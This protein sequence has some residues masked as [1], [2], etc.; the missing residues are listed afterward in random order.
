MRRRSDLP[1]KEELDRQT[2][3]LTFLP[4]MGDGFHTGYHNVP[5][6]VTDR[7]KRPGEWLESMARH[8]QT[9]GQDVGYSIPDVLACEQQL[10]R[11]SRLDGDRLSHNRQLTDYR[12]VLA[13]LLL[14]DS[15]PRDESWPVLDTVCLSG[16]QGPFG[17]AVEAALAPGR[18]PDGLWV[19]ILRSARDAE[20]AVYPLALLSSAMVLIPAA[21]PGN[22]SEV[23]PPCVRWYDRMNGCFTE[24]C[25]TISQRDAFVLVSRLRVLQQLKEQPEWQSPLLHADEHL[26][27]LLDRFAQDLL[28]LHTGWKQRLSQGGADEVSLLR[29][30]ALGACSPQ[31]V[32]PVEKQTLCPAQLPL[33]DNPLLS[34]LAPCGLPACPPDELTLYTLN[35]EA[36]A[37]RAHDTLFKPADFRNRAVLERLQAEIGLLQRHDARW[38]HQTAQ[39]LRSL[40]QQCTERT[41]LLDSLLQWLQR[42]ADELEAIPAAAV[43]ELVLDCPTTGRPAVLRGLLD[44]AIG[45]TDE[46]LIQNVFS[47]A[48]LLWEGE[49]AYDDGLLA[50]RCTVEGL[51]T[52]VAPLSPA[53][54][55]WLAQRFDEDGDSAPRLD[56]ASFC[57]SV[58]EDHVVVSFSITRRAQEGGAPGA[59]TFRRSYRLR[60]DGR[61]EQGGATVLPAQQRPGVTVWPNARFAPGLWKS[62]AVFVEQPGLV[63]AWA[64]GS[65]GWHQ[66]RRY[67]AGENGWQT[68]CVDLFPAFVVLRRGETTLGALINDTPR[69]LLKHEPPATAAI[70]FGSISTT[71]M[72]RQG[73]RVQPASLPE[74]MHR[75]LMKP[76]RQSDLLAGAFLPRDVLLPGSTTE[77][78]F[79]SVMDMFTDQPEQW[80]TVLLD[81]HIYYQSTLNALAGKNAS[82]LYYD[83][84][85]SEEAYAQRVMRLFLKQVMVQASLCARLWGSGLISWRVSMPNA[86]PLHRQESYLN[87]MRGLAR[88]VAQETGL[89]LCEDCP[90]VL[91]ATENQADGLYFLNRSEINAQ[92]G[93]LNL[94]IGGSTADLSLWLGGAKHACMEAS[95]LMGCRQM[96]FYS[97]LERHSDDFEHDFDGMDD[98]LEAA[99]HQVTA[100]FRQ[101]GSTTRGQRK[102][103]LLLDDL[104][105]SQ[106]Q[107]IRRC[108][109]QC[110]DEGRVSY[111]ECLL[112]WQIGFLFYLAGEMLQRAWQN[113]AWQPLLPSRM[114][115]CIAGNGGQLV[116]AFGEEQQTRLCSLTLARLSDG[117]PLQALLPIQSRHPKQEVAR[118]LLA[119][120]GRLQSAIQSERF[121]EG[122][123]VD[124][125]PGENLLLTYLP[126]FGHVFPQAAS[127]LMPNVF[128][129]QPSGAIA[130]TARMELDTIYANEAARDAGVDFSSYVRCLTA[131]KRLWNL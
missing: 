59:V 54:C 95:L 36:F 69:R 50:R 32:L 45:M 33:L 116:K 44:R 38:R 90:P 29:L 100:V 129:N 83:L 57:F 35:G 15:W 3:Y 96:L 14:W 19:F 121:A 117:H 11:L 99:I 118:G 108:M 104:L 114:E 130:A 47:D 97:L 48:L 12:A 98:E 26:V 42:W 123:R 72:L 9:N 101:E 63:S 2:S 93:Y 37:C 78:T 131:L 60:G 27:S 52:A 77:S 120:D 126:L 24:P 115:L 39:A 22:L 92:S 81:G 125:T 85:W 68:V 66:G 67:A 73:D 91:F 128:D 8:M 40:R 127:R 18:A 111:M 1:P 88:E 65:Q 84:K 58:Q 28:N 30:L 16:G 82:A 76:G 119:G 17:A 103:M 110:R 80:N 20:A 62:Y 70:D 23:L 87:L 64:Y 51:G 124:E 31:D 94:D 102:C 75:T 55:Q 107:A 105:S 34:V 89:P 4:H 106:A 49:A 112:L 43:C 61:L 13:L 25:E 109:A 10:R 5:G 7:N 122:V 53:L 46:Q 56:P 86:L 74:C 21:D 79:Y 6:V 71:V 113:E 41:G